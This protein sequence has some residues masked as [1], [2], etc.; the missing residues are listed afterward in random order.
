MTS[1]KTLRQLALLGPLSLVL[2]VLPGVARPDTVRFNRDIRPI[3]SSKCFF[4]HGPDANH[5][6]ADLRLDLESE[7]KAYAIVAGKPEASA[8]VSRITSDDVDL[9]MPPPAS[10]K[11]LTG[12]EIELLQRWVAEGAEYEGHWAFLTPTRPQLPKVTQSSWPRHPLD[13]FVLA[14]LEAANLEPSPEANRA[15]WLRRVTLDLTGLPPTLAE[16]DAYLEDRA[17]NAEERVVDRL[18]ASEHYGEHMAH[19]WLDAARYADTNGYQ[20]DLE[21][22][23]WVWRDWVIHA[24]NTNMPFD[25]FTIEQLAGDLLPDASDQQRLATGFHRNHPITIEGGVIDEEYRTEY[26]VDR[27]VTTSTVWLGLTMTCSRCHDHKYDPISQR[28]FYQ[29]FAFFNN[30]PERGLNG[31]AP[32][33]NVPSPLQSAA[34]RRA[35]ETLAAATHRLETRLA[36]QPDQLER[37][38]QRVADELTDTWT[39]VLPE[40]RTSQGGADF[41]PQPDQSV[42]VTGANPATDVYELTVTVPGPIHAIR[43]EALRYESLVNG[44]TGRS[45][46]ANFVLSEFQVSRESSGEPQSG[47]PRSGAGKS[48]F[49]TVPLAKATADYSQQGYPIGNAIDGRIDRSGW[50]VDGNTKFEDRRAIFFPAK[51]ISSPTPVR[52][53]LQLHFHWGGNH[54]I[55]RFRLAVAQRP[56]VNIPA[57]VAAVIQLPRGQRSAAQQHTLQEYLAERFG[58]ADVRQAVRDVRE[59]RAEVNELENVPA[60]MVMAEMSTPRTTRVLFRGEYDKPRETV[61]PGTPSALPPMPEASPR[62]RL[63]LARWL[64]MPEHPLTARVTVNRFWQQLFGTGIVK[65][66]EDFGSQGAWP[67]HPE[68]LDWLAVEFVESGW[69][70]KRLL[71]QIVLSATYRQSS[72]VSPEQLAADPENRLLSRGPRIRLDAEVIRDSALFASGLL[73]RRIGGPSV[74]PYHPAGLWQEINNRPGYS[75]TYERDTGAKLYRRSLYTFWKR[76]VPPP[77]MAAFDAPTREFCLVRRSRTNTPL[78]AFVMLH[79]PQFVEAARH[80]GQRMLTE[81][82]TNDTDRL[83]YGFRLCHTRFPT[84]AERDVLLEIVHRRRERYRSDRDAAERVVNVGESQPDG[85]LDLVELAAWT[86]AARTMLNLSEFITKP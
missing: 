42:L 78:Q 48:K 63:G 32:K 23:Q 4:C 39:I 6:E 16:I 52:V 74:F 82:T 60:T 46:N 25:Q 22:D 9:M 3:L 10:G 7:A 72:R 58:T 65:T 76:T 75:R 85:S 57:D 61:R 80:L 53:R 35:R 55:G 71:K 33:L 77:S 2:G 38:E 27:V 54:Q 67:S 30:V 24:F 14:Q 73:N 8:L 79:D 15:T 49:E 11:S 50:A 17:P 18:L 44:G 12:E 47:E 19:F 28:E 56:L 51:P 64:V 26:V 43:L 70:V 41:V 66:A 5:R 68:L 83:D 13:W 84:Q 20:Y 62:N 21:R 1:R 40:E 69:D 86:T 37:W 36:R 29:F 81:V 45:A 59:G 31:F 34:R